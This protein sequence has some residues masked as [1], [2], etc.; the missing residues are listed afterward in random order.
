MA[1]RNPK[2]VSASH[3][4]KRH[5]DSLFKAGNATTGYLIDAALQA[6]LDANIKRLEATVAK[7]KK[8]KP[9]K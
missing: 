8:A 9:P 1:T 3:R 5:A 2:L 4:V 7:I 6:E